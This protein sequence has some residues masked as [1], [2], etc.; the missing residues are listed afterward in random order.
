M[1]LVS[2]APPTTRTPATTSP[3]CSTVAQQIRASGSDLSLGLLTAYETQIALV[4]GIYL[5]EH[6]IDHVA[7]LA[8]AVAVGIGTMLK[9][10]TEEIY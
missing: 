9:M 6:K 1:A 4:I 8:P 3:A 10:P 7:H 5:H 2:S